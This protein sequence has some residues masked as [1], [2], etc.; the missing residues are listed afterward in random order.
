MRHCTQRP[1]FWGRRRRPATDVGRGRGA[2]AGAR[3]GGR[4]YNVRPGRGR[5][6]AGARAGARQGGRMG[7]RGRGAQCPQ[8]RSEGRRMRVD[9]RRGLQG[10]S[11]D[12]AG[13]L[14]K[15]RVE[16]RRRGLQ[17]SSR[18]NAG[19]LCKPRVEDRRRGLQGSSRAARAGAAVVLE[20]RAGPGRGQSSGHPMCWQVAG[21]GARADK[22]R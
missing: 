14:C 9:R 16:D 19:E 5:V 1:K 3:Q 12:N 17:G 6:P 20:G 10:S 11:R 13:E 18:D 21:T 7:G 4:M 15:P 8:H 2:R 22:W